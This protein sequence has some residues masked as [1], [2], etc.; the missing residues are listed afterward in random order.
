MKLN[1]QCCYDAASLY[2]SYI[3]EAV[4]PGGPTQLRS[5]YVTPEQHH[6][7]SECGGGGGVKFTVT[8]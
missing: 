1:C 6:A 5:L 8:R 2:L 7:N 3:E 4:P